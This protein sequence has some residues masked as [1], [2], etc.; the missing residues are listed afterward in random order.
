VGMSR[1]NT[2][3][4]KSGDSHEY[5]KLI[6]RFSGLFS[7]PH[8]S[9]CS[10]SSLDSLNVFCCGQERLP[11]HISVAFA[12]GSHRLSFGGWSRNAKKFKVSVLALPAEGSAIVTGR[13]TS[14]LK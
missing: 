5:S 2:T 9:S 7:G 6:S 8:G 1:F 12:S 14:L 13:P 11:S 3:G 4:L 10:S